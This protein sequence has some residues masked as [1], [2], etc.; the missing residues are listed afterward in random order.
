MRLH[1]TAATAAIQAALEIPST[2]SETARATFDGPVVEQRFAPRAL[3]QNDA[4]IARPERMSSGMAYGR[5][6]SSATAPPAPNTETTSGPRAG[7]AQQAEAIAAVV[8]LPIPTAAIE[9]E[10]ASFWKV[11]RTRLMGVSYTPYQATESSGAQ[12][13]A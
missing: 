5:K 4:T 3:I 8:A 12:K 7:P 13:I 6:P 10:A 2:T 9:A 11:F 1:K